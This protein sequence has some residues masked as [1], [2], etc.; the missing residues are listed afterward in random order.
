MKLDVENHQYGNF[1]Y[2]PFAHAAAESIEAAKDVLM[3]SLKIYVPKEPL[4]NYLGGEP[5]V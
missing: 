3:E 1:L 2:L 4:K 5:R